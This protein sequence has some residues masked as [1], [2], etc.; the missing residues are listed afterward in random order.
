MVTRCVPFDPEWDSEE[1]YTV[2]K[3]DVATHRMVLGTKYC[4][5]ESQQMMDVV[6]S[7][8]SCWLRR[9]RGF[10]PL[11]RG[12]LAEFLGLPSLNVSRFRD[13]DRTGGLS[14]CTVQYWP[15]Q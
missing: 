3:L 14:Y 1:P 12:I 5:R 10:Q 15:A 11:H 9:L 2:R 13:L 7:V 8:H 4:K 6:C